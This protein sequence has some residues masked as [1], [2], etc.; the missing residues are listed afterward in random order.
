MDYTDSVGRCGGCP[1]I[2]YSGVMRRTIR[3]EET[4]RPRGGD[5]LRDDRI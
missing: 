1:V 3:A 5:C 2:D 4:I